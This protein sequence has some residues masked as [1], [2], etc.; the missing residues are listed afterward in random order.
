MRNLTVVGKFLTLT[1][2]LGSLG[3]CSSTTPYQQSA[4]VTRSAEINYA[5]GGVVSTV[6]N[7]SKYQWFRLTKE[8]KNKQNSAVHA[9]LESEY[10]TVYN[11]YEHTAKGSVKAVHGYPQSSGFCKVI[12]STVTVKGKTRNFEE[13]AC[14]DV[15]HNG[16]RFVVR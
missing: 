6:Y 3:A 8:Q 5:N 1:V 15:G 7:L 2:L 11:W 13:T 14:Q 10:G 12:Y 16:W 4:S 9:A